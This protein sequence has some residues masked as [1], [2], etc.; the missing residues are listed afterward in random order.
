[1]VRK[2][3]R[4]AMEKGMK[5]RTAMKVSKVWP[6]SVP[7]GRYDDKNDFDKFNYLAKSFL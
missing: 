4:L 1:V 7:R 5:N 6:I 3:R 2:K